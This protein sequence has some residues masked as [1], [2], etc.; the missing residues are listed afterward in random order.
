MVSVG[1]KGIGGRGVAVKRTGMPPLLVNGMRRWPQQA[2]V[3]AQT[4]LEKVLDA[5]H[6]PRKGPHGRRHD[7]VKG[8]FA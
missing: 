4:L 8:V 2:I 1:D 6:G 7:F 3:A 5:F